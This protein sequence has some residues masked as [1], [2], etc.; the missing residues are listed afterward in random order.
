MDTDAAALHF[1]IV[2]EPNLLAEMVRNAQ[3]EPGGATMNLGLEGIEYGWEPDASH[4]IWKLDEQ[5]S[6]RRPITSFSYS[7]ERSW[8]TERAIR[9]QRDRRLDAQLASS[10]N[11]EKRK[12]AALSEAYREPDKTTALLRHCRSLLLAILVVALIALFSLSR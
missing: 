6:D 9:D 2:V 8:A 11:P 3:H 10:P 7:V 4:L 12:L 5:P 1:T